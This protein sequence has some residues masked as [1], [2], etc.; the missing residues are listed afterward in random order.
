M[1]VACL[2]VHLPQGLV[3][4]GRRLVSETLPLRNGTPR[5]MVKLV[6]L[7]RLLVSMDPNRS[8]RRLCRCWIRKWA[9]GRLQR[10]PVRLARRTLCVQTSA[11]VFC[12]FFPDLHQKPYETHTHSG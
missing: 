8:R 1:D 5:R 4:R 9:A 12:L 11:F 7:D 6:L 3:R 10:A 2:L